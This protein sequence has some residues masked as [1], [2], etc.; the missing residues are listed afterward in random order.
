MAQIDPELFISFQSALDALEKLSAFNE[1]ET[2]SP[3][4]GNIATVPDELK[5]KILRL[6]NLETCLA[7]TASC[8]AFQRLWESL[9]K[10]LVRDKVL[11]RVPWFQLNETSTGLTTWNQGARTLVA[12][13]R[14]CLGPTGADRDLRKSKGFVIVKSIEVSYSANLVNHHRVDATDV[15]FDPEAR[16]NMKPMFPDDTMFTTRDGYLHGTEPQQD[17][18]SLDLKTMK[19]KDGKNTFFFD[20]DDVEISN[21]LKVPSG[22][23]LVHV[24]QNGK[25][26][27]VKENNNLIHLKYSTLDRHKAGFEGRTER[28]T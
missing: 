19:G 2:A 24:S 4:T 17:N 25:I 26:G 1:T 10:T 5:E 18:V 23:E 14:L 11:R 9:D 6:S 8:A 3:T 22:L 16:A 7:L 12:R 20:S 21:S 15:T 13:T 27:F 28:F